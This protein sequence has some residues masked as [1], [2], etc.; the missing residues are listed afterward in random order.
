MTKHLIAAAVASVLSLTA[1]GAHAQGTLDKIKANGSITIGVRE[2]SGA[3]GYTLGNGEYVG[4]HTEMAKNIA[5]DVQKHLNLTKFQ[6]KYQ[7]ITSQ[8]RI[9]LVNNGK[10]DI[11]CG[12]TTNNLS[13]QR[14]VAFAHNT[15][16]EQVRIAVRA[17]SGINDIRDLN[18]KTVVTTTGTTI[19]QLLRQ[20]K[21]AQGIEFRSIM[22]RDHADS[23]LLLASGRADA[24][25]MDAAI[26]M[27]NISNS[28]NPNAFKLVGEPLATEPIACMVRR[29]DEAFL[30]VVNASIAR[31]AKDGTLAKLYDTWFVQ[32][33]PPSGQKVGLPLSAA[34]RGAWE[35][36]NNKPAEDFLK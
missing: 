27:G 9:S 34:T 28:K 29:G 13:R 16:I 24:F 22:G 25:V 14:D 5:H 10:V 33:V 20:N 15:Y 1:L 31:Q 19:V 6:I 7:P 17:D 23:F 8:N 18:G 11:E 3:L 4:F 26:L 36:L 12:T 32:P 21:R 2:S 35:Q 30:N